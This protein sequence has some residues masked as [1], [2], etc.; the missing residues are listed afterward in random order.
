MKGVVRRLV[1]L[2]FV[3]LALS[4][5]SGAAR[6]LSATVSVYPS[7]TTFSASA[8]APAHAASS[9]SLVMPIGGVDD[10][11]L[12]VRGA[13]KVA[14]SSPAIDAPLQLNLFF[15][16]Y[17]SVAGKPVPDALL[18]WDGSQRATEHTNQPVWLQVTIPYGTAPG[19]YQGSIVVVADGSRTS[20]PIAVTVS[21]VTLPKQSQVAGSLLTAFNFSPQSY[22]NKAAG[23]YGVSP[24]STLPGLFSFL[25]SYRLSPNSWG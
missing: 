15:A 4:A 22:A 8:A 24:E 7:G 9:V 21:P 10:A 25:A 19:T 1:L 11:T 14:I 23:L 6:S 20:V 5:G 16:H 13:Q 3:V 2:V 18:P 12:L 17:V